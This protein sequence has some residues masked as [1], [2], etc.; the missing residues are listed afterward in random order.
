MESVPLLF[1]IEARGMQ[2]FFFCQRLF[3]H[4]PN[5]TRNDKFQY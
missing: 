2:C 1:L 3:I 5:Q 4:H